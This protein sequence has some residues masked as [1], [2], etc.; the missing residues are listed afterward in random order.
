ME[1]RREGLFKIRRN[2]LKIKE[3]LSQTRRDFQAIYIC[4]KCDTE[5]TASGYDDENFHKNVIPSK[6]CEKCGESL[7]SQGADY[8]PLTTKYPDGMQL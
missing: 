7:I 1:F 3:I 6:I 2:K 5:E 8:R 4:E